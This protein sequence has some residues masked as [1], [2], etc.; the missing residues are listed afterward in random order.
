[1]GVCMVE[2]TGL[3]SGKQ[4]FTEL[5]LLDGFESIGHKKRQPP[6]G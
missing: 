5:L 6:K 1:M 2:T 3:D 4:Q